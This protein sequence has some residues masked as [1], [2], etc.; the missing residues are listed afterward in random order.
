MTVLS[1][2][3]LSSDAVIPLA[4]DSSLW[5]TSSGHSALFTLQRSLLKHSYV[6]N[7]GALAYRCRTGIICYVPF[8]FSFRGK[9][10]TLLHAHADTENP[11]VK[12]TEMKTTNRVILPQNFGEINAK[13]MCCPFPDRRW[14]NVSFT[15][16]IIIIHIILQCGSSCFRWCARL[17]IHQHL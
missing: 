9:S 3:S 17:P 16:V 13:N 4:F 8:F 6:S 2:T 5:K 14:L 12:H 15:E 7:V 11:S 1:L 10:L